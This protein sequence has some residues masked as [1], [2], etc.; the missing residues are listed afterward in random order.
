MPAPSFPGPLSGIATIRQAVE[1]FGKQLS[2]HVEQGPAARLC[3]R[4]HPSDSDAAHGR[5][6]PA[7]AAKEGTAEL[8][9]RRTG[10]YPPA[11]SHRHASS[12]A[13]TATRLPAWP[14]GQQPTKEEARLEQIGALLDHDFQQ[15]RSLW[16]GVAAERAAGIPPVAGTLQAQRAALCAHIMQLLDEMRRLAIRRGACCP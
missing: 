5:A 7:G 14:M 13:A 10:R 4:R 6:Q 12:A 16:P 9:H 15:K 8:Q 2:L 11:G 1:L 3:P